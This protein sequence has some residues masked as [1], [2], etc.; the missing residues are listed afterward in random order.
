MK[1]EAS[2]PIGPKGILQYIQKR[3]S[4][5]HNGPTSPHAPFSRAASVQRH[6]KVFSRQ[7]NDFQSAQAPFGSA[8]HTGR[9][10]LGLTG[11]WK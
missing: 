10:D 1:T 8:L 11:T 5:Q 6:L 7:V 3:F 4:P 9:A 2:D